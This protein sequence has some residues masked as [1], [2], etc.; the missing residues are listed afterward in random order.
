M[1]EWILKKN[2]WFTPHQTTT[3]PKRMFFQKL[4]FKSSLRLNGW[5]GG[6]Q[7]H[8]SNSSDDNCL[9][10]CLILLLWTGLSLPW[11]WQ[12]CRRL[13]NLPGSWSCSHS[14]RSR[15]RRRSRSSRS[16]RWRRTARTVWGISLCNLLFSYH[17]LIKKNTTNLLIRI[18]Y[19]ELFLKARDSAQIW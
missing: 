4:F 11:A 3:L 10:F 5:C 12:G 7:V 8:P 1:A 13:R 15:R 16:S 18:F 17:F 6:I 14:P 19:G 2:G 9:L